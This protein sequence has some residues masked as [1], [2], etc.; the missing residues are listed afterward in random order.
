LR[1][2]AHQISESKLVA[3]VLYCTIHC[4]NISP[5][6]LDNRGNKKSVIIIL[7][8]LAIELHLITTIEKSTYSNDLHLKVR[9]N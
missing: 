7:L 5:S 8:G 1:H 3:A 9:L 6:I 4:E 2:A